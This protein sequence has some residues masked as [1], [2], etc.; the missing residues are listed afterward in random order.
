MKFVLCYE[1]VNE[2]GFYDN[3][4]EIIIGEDAMNVRVVELTEELN[5][6]DEDIM[7]FDMETQW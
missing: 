3:V 6:N 7:V 1:K 4:W 2:K 5:C